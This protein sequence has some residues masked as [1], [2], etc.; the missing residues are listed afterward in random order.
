MFNAK[1]FIVA[2]IIIARLSTCDTCDNAVIY[3]KNFH[4]GTN[5]LLRFD[6]YYSDTLSHGNIKPVF[7]YADGSALSA[8]N[9]S[10][11]FPASWDES[12]SSWGNYLITGDSIKLEKFQ[13]IENNFRQIVLRGVVIKDEIHWV[14]KDVHN[15]PPVAVDYSIY[16]VPYSQKPDSILNWTRKK[17]KFNQ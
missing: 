7:L 3:H 5:A 2:A 8:N 16:F 13:H 11:G 9:Y 12:N 4:P 17:A 14:K 6:G 15:E 1:I 10:P